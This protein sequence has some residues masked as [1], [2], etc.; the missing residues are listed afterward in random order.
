MTV[1]GRGKGRTGLR[2]VVRALDPTAGQLHGFA[3][4]LSDEI[5]IQ[6]KDSVQ[7]PRERDSKCQPSALLSGAM[8]AQVSPP[9][10]P[11]KGAGALPLS[12]H[13]AGAWGR[14]V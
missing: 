3:K 8:W 5:Q 14:G 4:E 9:T 2:V 7:E 1:H 10:V 13:S 6:V 12:F 11:E